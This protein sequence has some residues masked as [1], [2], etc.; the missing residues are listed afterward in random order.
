[1]S[2]MQSTPYPARRRASPGQTIALAWL[3]SVAWH[4]ALFT[5]MLA[6]AW[7][8][9][10]TKD[11]VLPLA[12]TDLLGDLQDTRLEVSMDSGLPVRDDRIEPD[13][14]RVKPKPLEQLTDAVSAARPELSIVGIGTGGG[15]DFSKYGLRASAG[16][17]GP[18]F[19]GLGRQARGARRIVYVVD[20]SGS[21]MTTFDAV[22]QEMRRSV[23][24][25]RRSQKFHVICFNAG[26][27]LENKPRKLVPATSQQRE[28]LFEFLD[29][30]QAEGSTDPIPAM[31]RAFQVRP[32]LIYFLTDGDFDPA[33][34]ERLR[35]LNRDQKVKIFT[36]AYVSEGGRIL[37]EQIAR[38]NNGDF[39]FVS[40]HDIY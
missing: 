8:V 32:D 1:M 3:V 9:D 40:E 10:T 34:V 35:V 14:L 39:R 16:G 33:L 27:P 12:H 38:E 26:P 6:A 4:A 19:F 28:R 15:E 20:R 2:P 13:S 29:T 21:M 24:G 17:P 11:D 36:I 31:E 25:L 5:A 37:L 18:N 30:I 23:N 7:L 22:R